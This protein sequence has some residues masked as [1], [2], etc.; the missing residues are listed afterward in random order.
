MSEQKDGNSMVKH[1]NHYNIYDV[2]VLDM[3]AAIWGNEAVALWCKMTAFKYRMRMGYKK[4][5]DI[6]F[7]FKKE[8]ECLDLMRKYK[9]KAAED[10]LTVGFTTQD[11]FSENNTSITSCDFF[12]DRDSVNTTDIR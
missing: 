5:V 8:Q 3:M 7:D 6:N 12:N 2:E 10:N 9:A 11:K 4:G 1:P